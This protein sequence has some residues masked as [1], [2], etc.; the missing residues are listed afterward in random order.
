MGDR[1]TRRFLVLVAILL[2][3]AA[4]PRAARSSTAFAP[5]GLG[6]PWL[7][8]GARIRALGGAGAAEHGPTQFSLVNPASIAELRHLVIQGTIVPTHRS[9]SADGTPSEGANETTFPSL[10]SAVRLPAGIVL[11]G[12]YALGSDARF[13]ADRPE[14]SGTASTLRIEGT[15]GLQFIRLSLA[16]EIGRSVRIGLDR[17][18]VA[19]S[20]HEEWTRT[21]S[22]TLLSRSRDTLDVSYQRLGRWRFGAQTDLRGWTLG[23]VYETARRL[24]LT[25]TERAAGTSLTTG[26]RSL[27][28]PDGWTLGASGPVARSL[29]VAAQ[30]RRENWKRESLASDLVD[31]RAMTRYSFGVE[32]LGDREAARLLRKLPLRLGV[33]YLEWPDLL[34]V[35]GATTIAGGTAGVNEIT[36]SIG[37][38]IVTQDKV[39]GIDF[40]IEAGKRGDR[41]K[42][43]ID[44]RYIRAAFTLLVGDDSWK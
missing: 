16:K 38:S 41:A 21:F 43:G 3:G 1:A 17:E 4:A 44:E 6:E 10:R 13:R 20:F 18:I 26:S 23:G 28:I 19:G 42:L 34:P 8:E 11:G 30:Y 7:E 2:A 40:S 9:V 33:S 29:R 5:G 37:T 12:A 24:P 14:S 15:G 25:V 32:R 36:L 22:D 39:G 27:T 31:F 35:A